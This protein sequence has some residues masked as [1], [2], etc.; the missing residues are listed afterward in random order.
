MN[1]DEEAVLNISTVYTHVFSFLSL[2]YG[3]YTILYRYFYRL[4]YVCVC[5]I[6]VV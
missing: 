4:T 3:K 6:S 5:L 2:P 1:K